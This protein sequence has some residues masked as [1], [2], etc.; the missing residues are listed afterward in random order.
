[1]RSIEEMI[2]D[3]EE[4]YLGFNPNTTSVKPVHIANGLFRSLSGA[5][6]STKLLHKFVFSETKKG[7]VPRGHDLESIYNELRELGRL[8][9]RDVQIGELPS[10]RRL[11]KQVVN[12]DSGVF[13]GTM[14]SYTHGFS[15]LVTSDTIAS[16]G[17]DLVGTCLKLKN[18][19]LSVYI[20]DALSKNDDIITALCEPLLSLNDAA[21]KTQVPEAPNPPFFSNEILVDDND[22]PLPTGELWNG[23]LDAANT[24][25]RHL[26]RHPNKLYGL[27]LA[28]VFAC[29]TVIRHLT[30]AEAYFVEDAHDRIP[31]FL[32]DFSNSA[33][34]PVARASLQT[35]LRATQSVSRFYGWALGEDL[36]REWAIDE[37]A[38]QPPPLYKG[39]SGQNLVSKKAQR[40]LEEA[41]EI[42]TIA[43]QRATLSPEEAYQVFGEAIFDM[44]STQASADANKYLRALGLRIGLFYPPNQSTHRFRIAQDV[45]EVLVR[46]AVDPN[47][48]I[49]MNELQERLW[50]RY[51]VIV[52][53]KLVD[54]EEL[55]KVGVYQIDRNALLENKDN[56]AQS[57]EQ[58]GFASILAD[59]VFRIGL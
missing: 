40:E 37:L 1:M 34:S 51:R 15:H 8:D 4:R 44:F 58:L 20:N 43:Q 3:I 53:G 17:G 23:I 47:E 39:R 18:S 36:V 52:G 55:Q 29:F 12:A 14:Q 38:S 6:Y 54:E 56:F 11:L 31:P 22:T 35:Y 46:G 10:L 49:D 33:N 30:C 25:S 48:S 19:E 21:S 41:Q 27:R 50:S 57:L 2:R 24:L 45:L 7:T 28:V 16:D 5:T 13:T 32:L 26:N 9:D 59:G 42:W